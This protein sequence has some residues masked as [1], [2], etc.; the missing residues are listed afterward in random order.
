MSEHKMAV[1]SPLG[2]ETVA[3][4]AGAPRLGSLDGKTIAEM[5]NGDFKGNFTFPVIRELL[6]ERYRDVTVVPYT[7]FP[8]S[9]IR[10]TPEHQREVDAQMIALARDKGCDAVIAGNGG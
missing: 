5:W 7:E 6:H 3:A 9:T 8:Y 10:G 2:G 1:I 4:R